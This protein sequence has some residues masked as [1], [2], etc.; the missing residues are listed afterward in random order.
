[1]GL[2]DGKVAVRNSAGKL[3]KS[4]P[5]ALR[6]EPA[7]LALRQ[8]LEWL[9][10]HDAACLSQVETWMLRSLPVP[11]TV[12]VQVWPDPSW[13]RALRDAVVVPWG[14]DPAETGLL[15]DVDAER[16]VGLVTLDGDTVWLS[17][18][19]V[20]VPHP[21]LLPEV[22][23]LRAFLSDLGVEQAVGQL[24]RETWAKPTDLPAGHQAVHEWAGGRFQELRHLTSRASS[25][26]YSVRGGYSVVKVFEEARVVQ[27]RVWIG[28]DDPQAEAETG[29]LAWADERGGP[30]RLDEVGP[31][32]WSEGCRMAARL[33]AGRVVEEEVA[34]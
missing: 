19:A 23:E 16:G 26:G 6:D 17:T 29:E 4:V 9:T 15:R 27:G 22:E 7:V 13:Q 21:V 10:R 20:Q 3:L 14:G 18:E 25:L 33:H 32:A 24:F 30:L 11:A 12:L 34:A 1:M 5:P 31:V 2:V 8:V 28:A